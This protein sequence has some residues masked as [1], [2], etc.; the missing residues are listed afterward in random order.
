MTTHNSQLKIAAKLETF[1]LIQ[2]AIAQI[3]Q[4]A[5]MTVSG[6]RK[7]VILLKR[8]HSRAVELE[9]EDEFNMFFT[10][11]LNKV[12][13]IKRGER[14]A[15]NIAKFCLSYVASIQ[16]GTEEKPGTAEKLDEDD[17]VSRFTSY[18][19]KHLLR[20]LEAKQKNVRYRAIQFITVIMS[21]VS[22]MDEELYQVL[23]YSLNNRLYDK[24]SLVRVMAV[25]S[26]SRLQGHE[27]DDINSD[28]IDEAVEKLLNAIQN[29]SSPEVRKNALINLV[30]NQVTK[31]YILERA[32]DENSV[33][34]RNVFSN[35]VKK[36]GD[37]RT[38]DFK[39]REKLLSWGL[40][41]RDDSVQKAAV[42]MLA[43]E[44]F[45]TVNGDLLE[46]IER[47]HVVDSE[48]ADTA[49]RLFFTARPDKVAKILITEEWKQL[50]VETAFMARVF[51]N[52]C[53][54]NNMYDTVDKNFPE[55]TELSSYLQKYLQ[56][57]KK[58]AEE[59]DEQEATALTED[60]L[61]LD[62]VIQ[63]FLLIARD[64][65][66]SD[67]FGRRSMLQVL[68][69][70]LTND[71]LPD[72]LTEISLQ[73]LNKI[74]INERDF[75]S[76]VVEII[77]DIRDSTADD[78][79]FHSALENDDDGVSS[80][81]KEKEIPEDVWLQCLSIA[82]HL[83][84]LTEE[85][86]QDNIS[87]NS[88]LETLINPA[89]VTRKTNL[90][91]AGIRCLGLCCLLDK[92][93]A[94][95]NLFLFGLCAA[96]GD[97]TLRVTS[98]KT[99]IDVLCIH[100]TLVLDNDREGY[101]D[102]LSLAKLYYKTLRAVDYPQAQYVTAEGLMKLYFADIMTDD[103]LFETLIL[104]YH[105]PQN[106]GNEPL[107]QALNFCLPVYA[108]SHPDHQ[109]RLARVSGDAFNR[110]AKEYAG[111]N[112]DEQRKMANPN[113]ILQLIIDWTNP[114]KVVNRSSDQ[115]QKSLS[116][117]ILALTL[118]EVVEVS[119]TA[120]IRKLI[121]TNLPRLSITS[122]IPVKLLKP[123]SKKLEAFEQALEDEHFE[124]D[125][126]SSTAFAKYKGWFDDL[127][128]QAK[129][130][131]DTNA[132][133]T[134]IHNTTTASDSGNELDPEEDILE[135]TRDEDAEEESEEESEQEATEINLHPSIKFRAPL[136]AQK[137]AEAAKLAEIDR[138]LKE[139]NSDSEAEMHSDSDVEM[140]EN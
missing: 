75:C 13:P 54:E 89:I 129:T 38:I 25:R 65:D 18:I 104:T 58:M 86:L 83:L 117:V 43:N 66:F 110:L 41:D 105:N 79:E 27:C 90:R 40:K 102:H 44:W 3:F 96:R 82:Q 111:L 87:L 17:H 9:F 99:I 50:T 136:L 85:P 101:V 95:E 24:E 6:H 74:S 133:T 60:Q 56:L 134:I 62:F 127:F 15:E 30:I 59:T 97:E 88:I 109:E 130:L 28:R 33:I 42:K 16:P 45:E 70:S 112:G 69:S 52:H 20:G 140:A 47:L 1:E 124:L 106:S 125:K 122:Q 23:V 116:H 48:I 138:Q 53:N 39:T 35:V 100:G 139:L 93:L 31:D 135:G 12:L 98:I 49:L 5:Q 4:D 113:K 57:R 77:T 119:E 94:I 37:F 61:A 68:R 131:Q 118:L 7:Q 84:E 123:L 80:E 51:L 78:E 132:D 2:Q 14:V 21:G 55:A 81:K 64:Y 126:T 34:R 107:K 67:D 71:K 22:E 108:Y 36:F 19:L 121:F 103:D 114:E 73:V 120:V 46:F 91:A 8:I 72:K 63:Q 115:A 10:K 26:I 128:E 29:D 76:M 11:L 32:R 92:S 137:D